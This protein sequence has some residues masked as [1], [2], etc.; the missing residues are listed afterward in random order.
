MRSS[1]NAWSISSIS[2]LIGPIS[3][4]SIIIH[5]PPCS[6]IPVISSIRIVVSVIQR[7]SFSVRVISIPGQESVVVV[8]PVSVSVVVSISV[9]VAVAVAVAVTI[10]IS[11][12]SSSSTWSVFV[13]VSVETRTNISNCMIK[14]R[15]LSNI[16]YTVFAFKDTLSVQNM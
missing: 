13:V 6:R 11:V 15:E 8:R 7:S 3:V 2:V 5:W 9:P 4:I 12:A 10:A 14:L 16:T 1:P